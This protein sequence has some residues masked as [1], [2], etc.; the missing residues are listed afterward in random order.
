M[1]ATKRTIPLQLM[2]LLLDLGSRNHA[3]GCVLMNC[4]A[5]KSV[6]YVNRQASRL[7][8]PTVEQAGDVE[9]WLARLG[10]DH[11]PEPLQFVSADST[12][13]DCTPFYFSTPEFQVRSYG[14]SDGRDR[15]VVF[16]FDGMSLA[17]DPVRMASLVR[18]MSVA[19]W[20]ST[21]VHDLCQPLHVTHSVADLLEIQYQNGG[22]D[23]RPKRAYLDMLHSAVAKAEKAIADVKSQFAELPTDFESLDLNAAIQERVGLWRQVSNEPS[24]AQ[25]NYADELLDVRVDRL[26]FQLLVQCLI[27]ITHL[28][29]P[30]GGEARQSLTLRTYLDGDARC[31]DIRCAEPIAIPT[32]VLAATPEQ[33]L[34][35]S[36][37]STLQTLAV[38]AF[39]SLEAIPGPASRVGAAGEPVASSSSASGAASERIAAEQVLQEV[40]ELKLRLPSP[41]AKTQQRYVRAVRRMWQA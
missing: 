35:S 6:A 31:L 1:E 7:A 22:E 20:A 21:L 16:Y 18:S 29:S 24:I 30:R 39:G 23:G 15:W 5:P 17:M 8:K 4:G 3:S 2:G 38:A 10:L 41:Q 9:Y 40:V 34:V 33:I 19:A 36:L 32:A 27:E 12:I 14:V 28:G 13:V 25:E 37:W 26:Q 11:I